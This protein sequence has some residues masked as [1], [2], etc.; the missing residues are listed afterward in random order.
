MGAHLP[1]RPGQEHHSVRHWYELALL[2]LAVGALLILL[3]A[4]AITRW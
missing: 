4:A 2:V 1:G 3:G